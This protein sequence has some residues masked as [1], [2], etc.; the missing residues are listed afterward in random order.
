MNK[1]LSTLF[2]ITLLN[3]GMYAYADESIENTVEQAPQEKINQNQDQDEAQR[4]LNI[5]EGNTPVTVDISTETTPTAPSPSVLDTS[6]D[7]FPEQQPVISTPSTT[8]ENIDNKMESVEKSDSL[9]SPLEAEDEEDVKEKIEHISESVGHISI[10]TEQTAPIVSIDPEP[11]LQIQPFKT[12]NKKKSDVVYDYISYLSQNQDWAQ[13]NPNPYTANEPWLLVGVQ[14]QSMK[15][16]DSWG[17]LKAQYPISTAKRGVG[18][19]EH[20]Y[21]TPRGH[22]KICERIGDGLPARE[23]FS[24]RAATGSQYSRELHEQYPKKDWILT[25]IMWLCGQEEGK[26]KGYNTR[27]QVVDSYRRYI[28][29]H[30]AGDHAPFGVAPSSLGC[31][32]MISEDVIDLFNNSKIGTDVYIDQFK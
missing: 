4:A 24:R 31:V 2:F 14:T 25:R 13:T 12:Q 32:R 27:G 6:A 20:S 30:G 21:Q 18:E 23:I 15:H 28:Y 17:R 19:I 10:Q 5:L 7:A 1:S 16:F 26:N 9:P 3:F 29:I 22:H 11:L 8:I